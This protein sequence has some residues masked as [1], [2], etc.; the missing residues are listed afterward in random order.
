M[1]G[2]IDY[3]WVAAVENWPELVGPGVPAKAEAMKEI[4][5]A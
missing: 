1:S 3:F 4:E 5:W 2:R